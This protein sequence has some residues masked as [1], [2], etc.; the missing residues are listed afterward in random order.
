MHRFLLTVQGVGT[1]NPHVVQ[2]SPVHR[3]GICLSQIFGH[4]YKKSSGSESNTLENTLE[5]EKVNTI[6]LVWKGGKFRD[7]KLEGP[8]SAGVLRPDAAGSG[9]QP[10]LLQARGGDTLP[11]LCPLL[12]SC[13]AAAS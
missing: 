1:P 8:H 9:R 2:E 3:R 5:Y 12:P 10:H 6:P 13:P 4:S 11:D 7:R